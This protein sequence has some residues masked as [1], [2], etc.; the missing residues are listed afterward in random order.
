MKED[1]I[2]NRMCEDA[3]KAILS[4]YDGNETLSVT[5]EYSIFPDY[6]RFSI[7]DAFNGLKYAGLVASY[8][9]AMRCWS[10]YL[11]P[12]AL[13]YFEN[14]TSKGEMCMFRKLPS[15]SRALLNEI[16]NSDNP[17]DLLG[18]KFADCEDKPT[19]DSELRSLLRE[20]QQ[21]GYINLPSWA[22]NVPWVVEINNSARTYDE[23]EIEFEQQNKSSIN[24][25]IN[26]FYGDA[27]NVQIQQNTNKSK[28]NLTVTESIDFSKALEIF[29]HILSNI[30]SFNL[31]DADKQQLNSIV[32]EAKPLAESKIN[33]DAVKKSLSVIKDFFIGVSG[34][35]SAS[36]ILYM[37]SQMGV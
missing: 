14:K 33:S 8:L 31:S 28:Q 1:M 7:K 9:P 10:C 3:L 5:G 25:T 35:L 29:N 22:D 20:L 16:V 32:D 36:G 34:S 26:N 12:D 27:T 15:N 21:E 2:L 37:L 24:S 13:S 4:I 6:M 11:T 17:V 30:D 23:R 18:K 19:K